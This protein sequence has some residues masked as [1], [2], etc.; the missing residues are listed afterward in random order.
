MHGA[1][2]ILNGKLT[3]LFLSVLLA[4]ESSGLALAK[5]LKEVLVGG[6]PLTLSADLVR[7]SLTGLAFDGQYQSATE[8]HVSGLQVQQHLCKLFD[9]EPKWVLSRLDG[10]HRIELGADYAR[11]LIPFYHKLSGIVYG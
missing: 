3:A 7:A 10:A 5:L 8:G 1:I 4:P 11:A 6:K 2:L 9:L